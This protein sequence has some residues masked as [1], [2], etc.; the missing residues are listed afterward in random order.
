M[1][2]LKHRNALIVF[3]CFICG[4]LL[5]LGRSSSSLLEHNGSLRHESIQKPLT[6]L[7]A[8]YVNSDRFLVVAFVKRDSICVHDK[9]LL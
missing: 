6:L 9:G 3:S 1:Y 2:F 5:L 8:K 4:A 7:L